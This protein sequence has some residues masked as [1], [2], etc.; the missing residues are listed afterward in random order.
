MKKRVSQFFL[1]SLAG[2]CFTFVLVALAVAFV[3]YFRPLYYWDIVH[4]NL[5]GSYGLTAGQVQDNY[6]ALIDY[7]SPFFFGPLKFPDLPS[8]PESLQ[9]FVEVKQLFM[10]IFLLGAISLLLLAMLLWI[11]KKRGALPSC[12]AASAL[13]AVLLPSFVGIGIAICFDD[14]FVLFHKL[15]FRMLRQMPAFQC[16]RIS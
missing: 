9:H 5:A 10:A 8:S 3:L 2:T 14:A 1:N 4:L 12:L 6:D 7:N 11:Q 13:M 15:F 16:A